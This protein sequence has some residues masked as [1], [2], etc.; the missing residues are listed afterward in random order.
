MKS[1]EL[2]VGDWV[3]TPDG[4]GIIS[5]INA[6][7]ER[8][9]VCVIRMN[10]W[11][12]PNDVSPIPL[13]AEILEKNGFKYDDTNIGWELGTHDFTIGYGHIP[14]DEIEDYPFIWV[15]EKIVRLRYVHELQHALKLCGIEKEIVL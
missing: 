14:F 11:F 8:F 3:N 13:T 6:I 10:R 1:N 12:L 7:D 5:L 15:A 2:M 4:N 9:G